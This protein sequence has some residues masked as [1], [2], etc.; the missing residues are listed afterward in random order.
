MDE[1]V[2][3]GAAVGGQKEPYGALEMP[4]FNSSVSWVL[5]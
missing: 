5:R 4:V 2:K 1:V 3:T